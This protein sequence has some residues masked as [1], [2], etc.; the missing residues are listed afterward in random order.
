LSALIEGK[1]KKLNKKCAI[2][3]VFEN[4]IVF[5]II[6]SSIMLVADNPLNNKEDKLMQ[7]LSSIDIVITCLFI[8]EALI[9][10]I[11]KGLLF[12]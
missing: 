2:N 8:M 1:A 3:K 12:N 5:L 6:V 4:F 10:I 7:V 9:K 11:A